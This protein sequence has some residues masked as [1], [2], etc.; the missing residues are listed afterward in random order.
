MNLLPL[1]WVRIVWNWQ[2]AHQIKT[3]FLVPILKFCICYKITGLTI[4]RHHT[5]YS[6]VNELRDFTVCSTIIFMTINCYIGI[7]ELIGM[8]AF[9]IK[10]MLKSVW[11]KY[12]NTCAFYGLQSSEWNE[13]ESM[14][15]ELL[16]HCYVILW[17]VGMRKNCVILWIWNIL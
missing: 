15:N 1:I 11:T 6:K 14:W 12:S 5:V 2:R 13:N 9:V 7:S 4:C 16:R 3:D 8:Y 10:Y 17:T